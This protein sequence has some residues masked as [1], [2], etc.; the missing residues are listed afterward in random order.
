MLG[1]YRA[2]VRQR[3]RNGIAATQIQRKSRGR[4]SDDTVC[5]QTSKC[6]TA[7]DIKHYSCAWRNAIETK[8]SPAEGSRTVDRVLQHE[9]CARLPHRWTI[10]KSCCEIRYYLARVEESA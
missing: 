8:P 9:R 7:S 3:D 2:I 5:S 4:N 6:A 10:N 1:Q